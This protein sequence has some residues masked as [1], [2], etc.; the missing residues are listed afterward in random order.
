M[1]LMTPTIVHA[2]KACGGTSTKLTPH[3]GP[4]VGEE[5]WNKRA[6]EL[7]PNSSMVEYLTVNQGVVGS[8]PASGATF[9]LGSSIG[10]APDCR[11]GCCEFE[12]RPGR[13][14]VNI[15]DYYPSRSVTLSMPEL[16]V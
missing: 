14:N 6:L 10:R 9:W 16:R 1:T 7:I 4:C 8:S 5:S 3:V 12:P 15:G 2:T 13:Q 11:S